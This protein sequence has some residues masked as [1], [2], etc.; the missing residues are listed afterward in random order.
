M[1]LTRRKIVAPP[2]ALPQRGKEESES[3]TTLCV[4]PV[5][6]KVKREVVRCSDSEC[7]LEVWRDDLCYHHYR[8]SQGFV[9]DKKQKIYVKGKK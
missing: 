1:A 2:A 3:E 5:S 6:E 4:E 8:L 7:V 9:F